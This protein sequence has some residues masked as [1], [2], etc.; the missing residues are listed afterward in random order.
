MHASKS[1]ECAS[2]LMYDN[3][4]IY[5]T[6]TCK[7]VFINNRHFKLSLDV[8]HEPISRRLAAGKSVVTRSLDTADYCCKLQS[9]SYVACMHANNAY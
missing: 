3:E 5:K 4:F 7:R 6:N 8:A 1:W 2:E 9:W